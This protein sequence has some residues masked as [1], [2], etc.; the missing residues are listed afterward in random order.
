MCTLD[1]EHVPVIESV[2]L[3]DTTVSEMPFPDNCRLIPVFMQHLCDCLFL[4][5]VNC[6]REGFDAGFM[7]IFSCENGATCWRADCV[8][9]ETVVESHP[10]SADPVNIWGAPPISQ[11]FA[12][13]ATNRRCRMVVR[14]DEEYIRSMRSR[15]G[16]FPRFQDN[17]GAF[18][19]SGGFKCLLDLT[20][21]VDIADEQI[22]KG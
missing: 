17:L 20:H 8:R 12:S 14:H 7:A 19:R 21:R 16:L 5:V 11:V 13:I 18:V 2:R 15:H 9:A 22:E 6:I 1:G 3:A 10:T 4:C